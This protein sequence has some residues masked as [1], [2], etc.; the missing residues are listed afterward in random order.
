MPSK[1]T[2]FFNSSLIGNTAT[3]TPVTWDGGR[4]ALIV[5]ATVYGGA[6]GLTLQLMGPS[7]TWINV[8]SSF[9]NDQIFPF[10]A[11][12]GQYRFANLLSSSIGVQAVLVSTTY[13]G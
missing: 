9:L 1:G 12:P 7:Q 6:T 13:L 5:N 3:S 2:T 10:D 4:S 8:A 11:P